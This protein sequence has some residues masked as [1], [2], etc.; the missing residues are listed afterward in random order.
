MNKL[1]LVALLAVVPAMFVAN[2]AK[3]DEKAKNDQL[4]AVDKKAK[5]DQLEAAVKACADALK[6]S[7][8]AD[9]KA[10]T[11]ATKASVKAAKEALDKAKSELAVAN[12]GYVAQAKAFVSD[13][14]AKLTQL[15]KDYPWYSAAVVAA[16]TI[17]IV[18]AVHACNASAETEDANF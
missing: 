9:K 2:E 1:F 11:E 3:V 14:S 5:N 4:E 18:E 6:V 7:E 13:K 15:M 17:A 10:S 8:E 16:A 12:P